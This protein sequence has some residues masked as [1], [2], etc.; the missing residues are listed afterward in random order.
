MTGV[1]ISCKRVGILYIFSRKSDIP[2]L[3][4]FYMKYCQIMKKVIKAAK[5]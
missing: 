4:A 2:K 3:K 5:S 1:K